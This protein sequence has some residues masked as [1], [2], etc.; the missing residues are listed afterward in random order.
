MRFSKI[1]LPIIVVVSEALAIF[2]THKELMML[3]LENGASEETPEDS[4][5]GSKE[6]KFNAW[7]RHC[8]ADLKIDALDLLCK[9]LAHVMDIDCEHNDYEKQNALN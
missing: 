5:E 2:H 7:L 3:F 6:D 9:V 4:K 8:S 1:S